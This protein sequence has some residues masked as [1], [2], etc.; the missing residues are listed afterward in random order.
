MVLLV[1]AYRVRFLYQKAW[2]FGALLLHSLVSRSSRVSR[3]QAEGIMPERNRG[4]GC[5]IIMVSNF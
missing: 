1:Q 4:E 5:K 2:A 3:V